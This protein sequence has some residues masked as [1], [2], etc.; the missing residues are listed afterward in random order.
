M[1]TLCSWDVFAA[2]TSLPVFVASQLKIFG[3]N[4]VFSVSMTKSPSSS[5]SPSHKLSCLQKNEAVKHAGGHLN[6]FSK[7]PKGLWC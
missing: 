5:N 4:E 1:A 3:W 7:L 6:Y 2:T